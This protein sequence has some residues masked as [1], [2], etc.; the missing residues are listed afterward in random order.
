MALGMRIDG[1]RRYSPNGAKDAFTAGANMPQ[2]FGSLHYHIIFSS[3]HRASLAERLRAAASLR[4]HRRDPRK[5]IVQT[6]RRGRYAGPRRPAHIS[7]TNGRDLGRGAF[8]QNEFLNLDPQRVG[9]T[10]FRVAD[11]IRRVHDQLFEY[12]A[13]A[14]VSRQP[15]TAS[16]ASL[17]PGR[18]PGVPAK[19]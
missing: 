12:R 16:Q 3:K 14:N 5:S 13:S 1:L 4:I 11:L 19:A 15:G 7:L 6:R 18:V 10:R 2:S 9:P 17:V 8:D